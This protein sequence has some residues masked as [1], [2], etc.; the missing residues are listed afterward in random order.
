MFAVL[1]FNISVTKF[2]K[3]PRIEAGSHREFAEPFDDRHINSVWRGIADNEANFGRRR[4]NSPKS[5]PRLRHVEKVAGDH[6]VVGLLAAA[7]QSHRRKLAA[8][9]NNLVSD[10]RK[11]W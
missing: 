10:G 5:P 2:L 7:F 8:D 1:P 4:A 11:L 3:R 9:R 6:V